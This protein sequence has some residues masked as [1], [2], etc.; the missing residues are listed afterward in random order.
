MNS[1]R[2]STAA[3]SMSGTVLT[4]PG[5]GNDM[6]EDVI[7][8]SAAMCRMGHDRSLVEDVARFFLEDSPGLMTQ[9]RSASDAANALEAA[10]AAHTLKG[11][12]SNFNASRVVQLAAEI[13]QSGRA[14]RLNEIVSRI[15][16]LEQEVARVE[17]ALRHE[18]L[19]EA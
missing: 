11:L 15:D 10:H 14:G 17:A 12:A 2:N 6:R 4:I 19:H 8:L 5:L 9:I 16:P 3:L 13:E 1:N 7:D 18:V